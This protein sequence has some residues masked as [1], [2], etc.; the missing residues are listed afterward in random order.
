[1]E[2]VMQNENSRNVSPEK[3]DIEERAETIL[4]DTS[5]VT[6]YSSELMLGIIFFSFMPVPFAVMVKFIFIDE[7]LMNGFMTP[8]MI[9]FL[10]LSVIFFICVSSFT[11]WRMSQPAIVI[12]KD[13]ITLKKSIFHSAMTLSWSQILEMAQEQRKLP[14]RYNLKD[15][16]VEIL[17]IV[18]RRFDK[19]LGEIVMDQVMLNQKFIENSNTVFPILKKILPQGLPLESHR[20]IDKIKKQA[21]R[22]FYFEHIEFDAAGITVHS[23]SHEKDEII[24][25]E[26][27]TRFSVDKSAILSEDSAVLIFTYQK[28]TEIK[29]L[30]LRGRIS[31]E[32]KSLARKVMTR[33]NKEA[34]DESVFFFFK[35]LGPR[36]VYAILAGFLIIIFAVVYFGGLL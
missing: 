31:G 2:C 21:F 13:N 18:F 26:N 17:K 12:S 16:Y 23:D 24:P 11:V 5:V 1:M 15:R 6:H 19:R 27:I 29:E 20:H 33:I 3:N 8:P 10:I 35:S 36:L 22:P 7:N 4:K 30:T 28:D 32:T 25:W 9:V 14:S 34:I